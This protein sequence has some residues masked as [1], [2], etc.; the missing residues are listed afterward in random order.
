MIRM[1][2]QDELEIIVEMKLKMFEDTG[3]DDHLPDNAYDNILKSYNE[4]YK[5]D[6]MRHFC[7]EDEGMIVASAGGFIKE[8][9]PFCFYEPSFYGFIGDVYTDVE[10]RNN[11]Y[12]TRLTDR[13]IEWLKSKDVEVIR[14]LASDEG[15]GIYE[16]L[17]F[18]VSDEMVL[19]I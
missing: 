16:K 2:K 10:Y 8:D 1:V 4:L 17:G 6:K 11:G 14:L 7:F 12:A 3:V 5:Q 18:E 9:I 13:V 19:E 15:R